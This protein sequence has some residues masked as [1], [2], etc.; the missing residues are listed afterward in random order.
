MAV[1]SVSLPNEDFGKMVQ[2]QL[3]PSKVFKLGLEL[4][5]KGGTKAFDELRLEV[6]NSKEE[7]RLKNQ[8]ITALRGKIKDLREELTFVRAE[9]VGK[10]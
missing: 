6:E 2:R 5:L 1:C 9:L 3:S 10:K 4:S 8:E 7:I